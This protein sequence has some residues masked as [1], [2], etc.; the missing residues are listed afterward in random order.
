MRSR[1][2]AEDSDREIAELAALA[3]GSLAP[4]RRAALEARVAESPELADRLAEQQQAVALSPQRPR[5]RWR[6]RRSCARASTRHE[7]HVAWRRHAATSRSAPSRPWRWRPRSDSASS[8]TGSPGQRFQAALAPTQL[9]P[10]ASG[11]ATL[12]Q[13]LVG[14]ADHARRDRT[15]SPRPRTLLR[16]MAPQP[17]RSARPDRNVQPGPQ[18]HTLGRSAADDFHN[19]D[20]H[21]RTGGRRS[22]LLR[23]EGTR[24]N[25]DH[26][27]LT[28]RQAEPARSVRTTCWRAR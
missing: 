8:A 11:E 17:G 18:G 13:D 22:A 20:R 28:D 25:R 27:R 16:S 26:T 4:E 2:E 3:D 6:R 21:P 14:L 9:V 15:S 10:G 7:T 19:P 1:R 12:D 24:R 5:P 23:R